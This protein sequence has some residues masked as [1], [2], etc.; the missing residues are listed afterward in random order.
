LG[1]L[2]TKYPKQKKPS[3]TYSASNVGVMSSISV[4]Y[5]FSMPE[6]D[7]AKQ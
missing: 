5:I 4:H 7:T 2:Q 6:C 1:A 3:P